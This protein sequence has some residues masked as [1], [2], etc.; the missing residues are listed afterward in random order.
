MPLTLREAQG[1]STE[2]LA[3]RL[4]TDA[5]EWQ[6]RID[7]GRM[8]PVDWAQHGVFVECRVL[9]GLD[10]LFPAEDPSGGSLV[11]TGQ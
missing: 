10:D 2:D 5:A 1:L 6:S 3:R 11:A 9:A 7:S 4:D 8:T